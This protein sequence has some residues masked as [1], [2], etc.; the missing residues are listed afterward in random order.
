MDARFVDPESLGG[1]EACLPG[2]VDAD[3][4]VAA[5][6][7]AVVHRVEHGVERGEFA[8]VF[9]SASSAVRVW[10]TVR[11]VPWITVPMITSS[12]GATSSTGPA[13]AQFDHLFADADAEVRRG[14]PAADL[15]DQL[16]RLAE[17]FEPKHMVGD[18]PRLLGR[19]LSPRRSTRCD[20]L[21]DLLLAARRAAQRSAPPRRVVAQRVSQIGK[22]L[23][24]Q[25]FI[26][27][28]KLLYHVDKD[29]GVGLGLLQ[30]GLEGGPGEILF[31]PS[32]ESPRWQIAGPP[33]PLRS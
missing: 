17:A 3:R 7:V 29:G 22:P 33:R 24:L 31:Q 30:L 19:R 2:R 14:E 1:T 23:Q 26:A 12:I 4:P 32:A 28:A 20:R 10:P 25:A 8:A 27:R 13:H 16:R 5:D 6:V 9:A 15:L 18:L 21:E 11:P